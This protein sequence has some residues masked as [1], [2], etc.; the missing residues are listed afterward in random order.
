M[1]VILDGSVSRSVFLNSL[2]NYYYNSESKLQVV[3]AYALYFAT[4]YEKSILM[5]LV[6]VRMQMSRNN[7][8]LDTI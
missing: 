7:K 1:R 2:R 4:D 6:H 5:R 8:I 3:P